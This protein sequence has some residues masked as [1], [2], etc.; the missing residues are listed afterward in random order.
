MKLLSKI[1]IFIGLVAFIS[2]CQ[3]EQMPT[4]GGCSS[5]EQEAASQRL[6]DPTGAGSFGTAGDSI[7]V[8]AGDVNTTPIDIVGG[9]DDDRDGGDI[10]GGGD[11]DRDGGGDKKGKRIKK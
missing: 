10:V 9:T 7:R 3:K 4:P 8:D 6:G 1:A 5:H 2:S 11:D